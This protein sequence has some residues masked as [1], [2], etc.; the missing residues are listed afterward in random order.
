MIVV[1][2]TSS[3][4]A[5]PEYRNDVVAFMHKVVAATEGSERLLE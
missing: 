5:A 4:H 2:P 3:H 1:G